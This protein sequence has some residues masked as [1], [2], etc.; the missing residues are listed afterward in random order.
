MVGQ[1][2]TVTSYSQNCIV[3]KMINVHVTAEE[4]S[5]MIFS[6]DFLT[7]PVRRGVGMTPQGS[8]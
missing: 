3:F 5:W 1:M 2:G 4:N 8:F 7:L 6:D